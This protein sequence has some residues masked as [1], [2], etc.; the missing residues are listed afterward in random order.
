[1][2][3]PLYIAEPLLATARTPNAQRKAFLRNSTMLT[4]E[5]RM[6]IDMFLEPFETW[7]IETISENGGTQFVSIFAPRLHGNGEIDFIAPYP[8][9]SQAFELITA[10]PVVT[11]VVSAIEAEHR[12]EGFA[13][14]VVVQ[15]S[16]E[17]AELL[18]YLQ[19]RTPGAIDRL[20][21]AIEVVMFHPIN[22]R[23]FDR[24]RGRSTFEVSWR[25]HNQ[26]G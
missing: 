24:R 19:W 11:F 8:A 6:Q 25:S 12:L 9:G 4:I 15:Q 10:Y 20:G 17:R 7:T 13:R 5:Q 3:T 22:L 16:W 2:Y 26:A 23:F 14:A 21:S 18:A 1:M